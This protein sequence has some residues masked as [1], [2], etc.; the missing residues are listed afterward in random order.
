MPRCMMVSDCAHPSLP[1]EARPWMKPVS[2]V[3]VVSGSALQRVF[4]LT[5]VP[6][7]LYLRYLCAHT[8]DTASTAREIPTTLLLVS[9]AREHKY[10]R[11]NP[12]STTDI[13]NSCNLRLT[14]RCS[15]PAPRLDNRPGWRAP[16]M[17]LP[18]RGASLVQPAPTGYAQRSTAHHIDLR[19]RRVICAESC[20]NGG[21]HNQHC[22]LTIR[23]APAEHRKQP[24]H[25]RHVRLR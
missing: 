10:A 20:V 4:R 17:P 24:R 2:C 7:G 25:H 19:V 12:A 5:V 9:G 22:V 8:P 15:T 3:S 23:T 6:C 11:Y 16:E 21:L 1:S 14:H 18:P 13:A